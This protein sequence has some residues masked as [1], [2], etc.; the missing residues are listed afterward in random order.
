MYACVVLLQ[1][2]PDNDSVLF[3]NSSRNIWYSV[4]GQPKPLCPPPP[5]EWKQLVS[6]WY[7]LGVSFGPSCFPIIKRSLEV[8]VLLGVGARSVTKTKA[9]DAASPR[10]DWWDNFKNFRKVNSAGR[11]LFWY[12][13][14]RSH[15]CQP[16]FLLPY[17][18]KN[19]GG[20]SSLS[21]FR[22]YWKSLEPV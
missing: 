14:L 2:L 12:K 4:A 18:E 21:S 6:I 5:H 19:A 13:F 11:R 22:N 16:L 15:D 10:I 17:T 9:A 20:N 7:F 3:P 8:D 1:V